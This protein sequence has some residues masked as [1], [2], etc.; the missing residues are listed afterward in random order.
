MN[1]RSA[2]NRERILDAALQVFSQHGF[3]S[4]GMRMIAAEAGVSVGAVYLYFRNKEE[5]YLTLLLQLMEDLEEMTRNALQGIDDP[6]A[7]LAEFIRVSIDFA[8]RY[9][10]MILL[11]GREL[12][13]AFGMESRRSFFRRRRG[14][15]EDIVGKGI[16]DGVFAES[17]PVQAGRLIFSMLR[18]FMV[19]MVY[20][21]EGLFDTESCV[22]FVLRSLRVQS[23]Q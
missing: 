12:G 11:Q 16:S 22:Q 3:A 18:G 17:D 1:N 9:R 21:E 4:S 20:D 10:S 19:S 23:N 14:L 8:L 6:A 2:D 5:L 15:I 13:F 7:A